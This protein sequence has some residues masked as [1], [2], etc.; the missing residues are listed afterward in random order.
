MT[1]QFLWMAALCACAAATPLQAAIT[2]SIT[3][4]T[5]TVFGVDSIATFEPTG[6]DMAG[7]QVQVT[8][9]DGF[10]QTQ[11]WIA[12]P[13]GSKS[14]SASGATAAHGWSLTEQPGLTLAGDT[15]GGKWSLTVSQFNSS[16]APITEVL[17]F[18]T[19]GHTVFDLKDPS[20][21]PLASGMGSLAF[22]PGSERGWTFE[23]F[24]ESIFSAYNLNINAS[25]E[26]AV[27]VGSHAIEN[28]I[29]TTLRLSFSGDNPGDGLRRGY[30][31]VFFQDTDLAGLPP[32]HP[33]PEPSSLVV[34][35]GLAAIGGWRLRRRQ[36]QQ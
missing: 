31:L 17:L 26:N 20:E 36:P 11:A 22:T 29:F 2:T 23:V 4:S 1:K 14:G 12:G 13:V 15:F 24:N 33:V 34:F 9:A 5:G 28:D 21:S 8:F 32:N 10:T 27:Q 25:Y 7:M 3:S 16:S 18:G 19:P 30:T 35:A 6:E